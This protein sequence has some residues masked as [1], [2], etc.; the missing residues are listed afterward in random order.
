M[1]YKMS[2]ACF[3]LSIASL[4]Y[5]G[6]QVFR[7]TE[8]LDYIFSPAAT[9]SVMDVIGVAAD[10]FIRSLVGTLISFAFTSIAIIP[11]SLGGLALQSQTKR[12]AL[13]ENG[14]G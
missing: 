12:I 10:Q 14:E 3:T 5:S 7:L 2:L 6:F 8:T 11:L 4:M 9:G 13:N 1:Y